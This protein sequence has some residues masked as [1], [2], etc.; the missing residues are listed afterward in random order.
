VS[1]HIK[2]KEFVAPAIVCLQKDQ[3]QHEYLLAVMPYKKA[4]A[5]TISN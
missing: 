3:L 4:K 5:R 2:L 1:L